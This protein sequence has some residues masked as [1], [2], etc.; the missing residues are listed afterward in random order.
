MGEKMDEN[1]VNEVMHAHSAG[2]TDSFGGLQYSIFAKL[3]ADS[4]DSAV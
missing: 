3:A 4:V 2:A 1:M